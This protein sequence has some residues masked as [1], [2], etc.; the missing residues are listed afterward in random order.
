MIP[1]KLL[2]NENAINFD[3]YISRCP[4]DPQHIII[5]FTISFMD[6]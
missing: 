6:Y 1:T 5:N 2:K 4:N 3:F